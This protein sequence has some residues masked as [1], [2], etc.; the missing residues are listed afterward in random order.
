MQSLQ[1]RFKPR[2]YAKFREKYVGHSVLWGENT[3]RRREELCPVHLTS[4]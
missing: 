3:W 4:Q 2:V 1:E